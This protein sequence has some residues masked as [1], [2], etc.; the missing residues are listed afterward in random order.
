MPQNFNK[1]NFSM[2]NRQDGVPSQDEP[3]HTDG[4]LKWFDF[5]NL[6]MPPPGY[7]S[8]PFKIARK[9]V[10]DLE[11]DLFYYIPDGSTD[12]KQFYSEKP[13][14]KEV[15]TRANFMERVAV[16]ERPAHAQSAGKQTP[17]PVRAPSNVVPRNPP[18]PSAVPPR[19]EKPYVYK[20]R[21]SAPSNPPVNTL[22]LSAFP[23]STDFFADSQQLM[24]TSRNISPV[25]MYHPPLAL[26]GYQSSDSSRHSTPLRS[27]PSDQYYSA[28]VLPAAYNGEYSS[29]RRQSQGSQ[30][31]QRPDFDT[32]AVAAGQAKGNS[33]QSAPA[34]ATYQPGSTSR[35]PSSSQSQRSSLGGPTTPATTLSSISKPELSAEYID[36]LQK[37]PYLVEQFARRQK[38]YESPYSTDGGYATKYNP[39]E[40]HKLEAAAAPKRNESRHTPKNSISNLPNP[41]WSPPSEVWVRAGL[42]KPPTPPP[43]PRS[44][45]FPPAAQKL[46]SGDPQAAQEYTRQLQGLPSTASRNG[47]Q[48]R[49]LRDQG[50]MP[51]NPAAGFIRN[52]GLNNMSDVSK[53]WTNSQGPIINPLSES[54]M[55]SFITGNAAINASPWNALPRTDSA[56]SRKPPG[57]NFDPMLPQMGGN[58]TWRYS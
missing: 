53:M 54:A 30:T 2:S 41:Q 22:D 48:A 1:N 34:G 13:G 9:P 35:P 51:Y 3:F 24:D 15:S 12:A 50:V 5:Y 44:Q 10:V 37:Y 31:L 11:A 8:S 17:V 14:S 58:E 16:S 40:L 18:A 43:Q 21:E 36:N 20:P 55:P 46:P 27:F 28:K 6:H 23:D 45:H 33:K 19:N 32:M 57:L 26:Y 39:L 52:T 7:A 49:M 56:A 47:A 25:R 29:F 42:S 4:T 38:A